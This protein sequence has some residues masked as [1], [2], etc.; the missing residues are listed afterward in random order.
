M[1]L[2]PA[3][4]G[5]LTLPLWV[6]VCRRKKKSV[7]EAAAE[8]VAAAAGGELVGSELLEGS[9][10]PH[11]SVDSTAAGSPEPEVSRQLQCLMMA[12]C[13]PHSPTLAHPLGSADA[14]W[15]LIRPF[16]QVQG[17]EEE[18]GEEEEARIQ[19]PAGKPS[20]V[21]CLCC[22]ASQGQARGCGARARH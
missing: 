22:Q 21:H 8:G 5:R 2:L 18:Q 6:S 16:P 1:P 7:G 17:G 12:A 11:E 14:P 13:H 19:L 10:P 9:P 20:R 15:M 4:A 3:A